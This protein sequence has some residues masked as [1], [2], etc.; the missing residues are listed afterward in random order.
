MAKNE[1]SGMSISEQIQAELE[2]RK[3]A[4]R[5][6]KHLTL[7]WVNPVRPGQRSMQAEITE[8]R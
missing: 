5:S 1:L 6:K 2:R 4:I 3:L 8:K 7:I